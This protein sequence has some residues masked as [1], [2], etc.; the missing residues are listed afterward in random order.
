MG[1]LSG[2]GAGLSAHDRLTGVSVLWYYN[3]NSDPD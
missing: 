1:M 3:V 2:S